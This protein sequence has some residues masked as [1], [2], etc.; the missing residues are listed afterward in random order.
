MEDSHDSHWTGLSRP[1]S[2]QLQC[3]CC[4]ATRGNPLEPES[5]PVEV[6]AARKD[7]HSSI[8]TVTDNMRNRYQLLL[9]YYARSQKPDWN[10]WDFPTLNQTSIHSFTMQSCQVALMRM[11]DN[12]HTPNA[13]VLAGM[14]HEVIMVIHDLGLNCSYDRKSYVYICG[15]C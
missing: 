11:L 9:E 10:Q 1:S 2:R 8:L 14:M 12:G 3:P 7:G 5:L 15:F 4:N 13:C 6:M